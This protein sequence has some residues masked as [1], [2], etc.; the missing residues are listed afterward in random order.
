MKRP[1]ACVP[2][3]H[4]MLLV[5]GLSVAIFTLYALVHLEMWRMF[6]WNVLLVG[7]GSIGAW[8]AYNEFVIG[9]FGYIV[10]AANLPIVWWMLKS[11]RENVRR[12]REAADRQQGS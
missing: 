3:E 1:C 11:W 9:D 12:D 6:P 8:A 10:L 5:L 2:K 4:P 7:F